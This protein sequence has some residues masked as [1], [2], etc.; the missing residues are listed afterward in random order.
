MTKDFFKVLVYFETPNNS[1]A[2][3]VEEYDSEDEYNAALPELEA[4]AKASRMIVT[5]SIIEDE[6]EYKER[7]E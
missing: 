3:I 1:Y 4:R 7:I 6:N 2:E 5:E